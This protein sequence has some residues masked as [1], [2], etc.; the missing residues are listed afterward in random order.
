MKYA[1][2]WIYY[3]DQIIWIFIKN[4]LRLELAL[5]I[6]PTKRKYKDEKKFQIHVN[7]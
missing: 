3:Y 4:I 6:K 7:S 1:D 2:N 5:Y